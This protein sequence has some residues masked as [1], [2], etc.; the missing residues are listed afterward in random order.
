[1]LKQNAKIL[2]FSKVVMDAFFIVA[3]LF[4][5]LGAEVHVKSGS[6]RNTSSF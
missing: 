5:K 6:R 1:M 4:C 2:T 3:A